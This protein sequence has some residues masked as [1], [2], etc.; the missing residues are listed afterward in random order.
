[1]KKIAMRQEDIPSFIEKIKAQ[2]LSD[3]GIPER[4][5]LEINPT[6][7]LKDEEKAV[8]VFENEAYKKM[9]AL[10]QVC[11]K[12]I[13][14]YGTVKREGE[15]RFVVTDI[16]MFPQEVTGVTVQT[17]DAE[18]TNWSNA[19]SDE[20]FN[21]MRFYGHS[22][23]NMGCSPSGVDTDHYKNMIQN[24]ND[25]YIF[26]IFNKNKT[27]NY[28]LNIY[29]IENNVLYEKEDIDYRYTMAEEEMWAE[30]SI[31]KYVKERKIYPAASTYSGNSYWNNSKKNTP[32]TPA[33]QAAQAAKT[34]QSTSKGK[35][36]AA[37]KGA[38]D[39][40]NGWNNRY[41]ENWDGYYE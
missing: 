1:M 20:V 17:D 28:W 39:Y 18:Y 15:K 16:I 25:F 30:D 6:V 5:N 8:V 35:S 14:W 12:E 7:K 29:D 23:V 22:H 11:D 34:V 4:L 13:G 32:A 19:L 33:T 9:N 38:W 24:C 37:K 36:D 21:S 40:Y 26:G 3:K 27:Y 31:A 2:L 10:V 41:N